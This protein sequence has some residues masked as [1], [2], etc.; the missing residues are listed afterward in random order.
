MSVASTVTN[1]MARGFGD[2]ALASVSVVNKTMKL[3]GSIIMGFSNGIQ[4]VVV[5]YWGAKKYKRIKEAFWFV[6]GIGGAMSLIMGG[7]FVF[8]SFGSH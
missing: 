5:Q 1:N 8:D 7:S 3:L 6:V 4:P 2:Y